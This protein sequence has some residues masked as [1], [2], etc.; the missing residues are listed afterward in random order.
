MEITEK[1]EAALDKGVNKKDLL[2]LVEQELNKTRVKTSSQ[3]QST[4][5]DSTTSFT[6]ETVTFDA[7][8]MLHDI[9]NQLTEYGVEMDAHVQTM[10]DHQVAFKADLQFLI[11]TQKKNMELKW[12]EYSAKAQKQTQALLENLAESQSSKVQQQDSQ[13]DIL[14]ALGKIQ[15][16]L[17]EH[18]FISTDLF[19]KETNVLKK[20]ISDLSET[21]E[22]GFS[23][24]KTNIVSLKDSARLMEKNIEK[25]KQDIQFRLP[26]SENLTLSGNVLNDGERKGHSP[27]RNNSDNI[28]VPFPLKHVDSI[29]ESSYSLPYKVFSCPNLNLPPP[30]CKANDLSWLCHPLTLLALICVAGSYF[31]MYWNS[32]TYSGGGQSL[33]R[34]WFK[35]P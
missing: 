34:K 1:M 29:L 31:L 23:M 26:V 4:T 28:Y 11:E 16:D 19:R 20:K 2:L 13:Q 6:T 8:G 5:G 10:K 27:K 17:E 7:S 18:Q 25:I 21:M 22:T 9:F 3:T 14:L 12:E 33:W 35:W 15:D 30:C 24:I 32:A